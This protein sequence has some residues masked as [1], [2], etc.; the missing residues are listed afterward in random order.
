MPTTPQIPRDHEA[1]GADAIG[2]SGK[3]EDERASFARGV[4]KNPLARVSLANESAVARA[5]STN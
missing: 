3:S 2:F 4:P 5:S 1:L